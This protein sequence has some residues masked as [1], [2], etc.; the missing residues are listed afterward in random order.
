MIKKIVLTGGP[1]AGKSTALSRIESYLLDKGYAVL[2]VAESATELIHGGIRPFGNQAIYGFDFQGIILDYQLNKEK[3]YEQA[4]NL[5]EATGR[6][7]VIIYDRGVL[8]N[9]AYLDYLGWQKLLKTRGLKESDLQENY[10]LV[11]H[12][13][14]AALGAEDAYTLQN[15][16]AR[17]ETVDEAKELDNRTM[18][19]WSGHQNLKIIDNSCSFN[20]KI[21]NV[22]EE[23][24]KSLGDKTIIR[25]QRKFV[26]DSANLNLDELEKICSKSIIQQFYFQKENSPYEYRIRKKEIDGKNYYYLTI[27]EK[28]DNGKSKLIKEKKL[29]VNEYLNYLEN[30]NYI[31]SIKK[32]RYTFLYEK[33]YIRLDLFEDGFVLLEIE[34]I[35][36]IDEIKIPVGI[37]ILEEV[38]NKSSYQNVELAKMKKLIIT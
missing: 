32:T 28:F 6:D 3:S 8:D 17:T 11:I 13:V 33:E 26:V 24:L 38:S 23:C 1:C 30:N 9:K 35:S 31:S 5:L 22:L 4:A 16:Q 36:K 7:V 37:D 15:N 14:T 27:Q 2:I 19:A 21:N 12:M 10:D 34:P 25:E 20:E 18:Q 29:S